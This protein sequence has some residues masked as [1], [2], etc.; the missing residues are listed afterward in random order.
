MTTIPKSN[1]GV[2]VKLIGEDG[3]AY[4]ILGKVSRALRRAGYDKDFVNE[5]RKQATSGDYDHL[6]MVTMS[7]VEVE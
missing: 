6:L 1:T 7:Y 5:Y 2:K 3:N 4:S